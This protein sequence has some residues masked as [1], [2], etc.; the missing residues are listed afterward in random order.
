MGCNCLDQVEESLRA[1]EVDMLSGI[2]VNQRTK[3]QRIWLRQERD[4]QWCNYKSVSHMCNKEQDKSLWWRIY[5]LLDPTT[6][7]AVYIGITSHDLPTRLYKHIAAPGY[8][9]ELK[10]WLQTLKDNSLM[11]IIRQID[12]L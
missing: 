12:K 4:R 6:M 3:E 1:H 2:P 7:T 11:P 9:R 8:N 5:A 10:D